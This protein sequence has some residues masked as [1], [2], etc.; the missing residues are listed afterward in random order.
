MTLPPALASVK[1]RFAP[2]EPPLAPAA[3]LW[4]DGGVD[5]ALRRL[6]AMV[7]ARRHRLEG[8]LTARALL[9]LGK[10]ED[11]PWAPE[12]TYLGVDPDAPSLLV[13]TALAPDVPVALLERAVLRRAGASAEAQRTAGVK[14][15]AVSITPSLLVPVSVARLLTDETLERF[16]A[17]R[18]SRR[19][20]P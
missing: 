15:W 7:A 4:T 10:R 13:P 14:L 1:V 20:Q 9:V 12:V 17:G 8:V 3:A 2:R 18:A 16:R 11:L 6:E 5:T 19:E